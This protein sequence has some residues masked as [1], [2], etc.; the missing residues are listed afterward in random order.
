[1]PRKKKE[2]A[3]LPGTKDA[4]P[5]DHQRCSMLQNK[6]SVCTKTRSSVSFR[7]LTVSPYAKLGGG[8]GL[9]PR[10]ENLR[11]K[12][13]KTETWKSTTLSVEALA[14]IRLR[15]GGLPGRPDQGRNQTFGS[16]PSWLP[17][18]VTSGRCGTGCTAIQDGSHP[19]A[20]DRGRVW[21]IARPCG[22]WSRGTSAVAPLAAGSA[23]R[24]PGRG[25]PRHHLAAMPMRDHC[26]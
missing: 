24:R 23:G 26:S 12:V 7:C 25:P 1:M 15:T 3:T 4:L 9:R 20:N 6:K 16:W 17:S 8:A 22:K 18:E 14:K 10:I 21:R 2:E 13:R 5:S 19:S 11:A